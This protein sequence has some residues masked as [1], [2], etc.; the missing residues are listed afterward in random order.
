M[1]QHGGEASGLAI[2]E[3]ERFSGQLMRD[4]GSPAQ[5]SRSPTNARRL[6]RNTASVT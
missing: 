2:T 5:T 4:A 6:V 1:N 3:P